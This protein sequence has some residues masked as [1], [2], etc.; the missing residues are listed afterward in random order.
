LV[1][2]AFF[3]AVVLLKPDELPHPAAIFFRARSISQSRELIDGQDSGS[4]AGD[5]T[6]VMFAFENQ[7]RPVNGILVAITVMNNTL[8]SSGRPAM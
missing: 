5:D 3:F 1:Y 2:P 8:A 4:G 6:D 7:P